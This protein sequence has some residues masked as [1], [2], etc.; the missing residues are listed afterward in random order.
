M[1]HTPPDPG[2][3]RDHNHSRQCRSFYAFAFS[4]DHR[5]HHRP[6]GGPSCASRNRNCG[7]QAALVN[8][9]LDVTGARLAAVLYAIGAMEPFVRRDMTLIG[10]DQ[11]ARR[12]A[13]ENVET[14][15]DHEIIPPQKKNLH[16]HVAVKVR[17]RSGHKPL[18]HIMVKVLLHV[19]AGTGSSTSER[20]DDARFH[21][22][23][24]AA[25]LPFSCH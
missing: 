1:A 3:N 9:A 18:P 7:H 17:I 21:R 14:R 22:C 16:R 13:G 25:L 6:P 11:S 10:G 19:A 24:P 4:P 8:H 12:A 20:I 15:R 5:P 2:L 23:L